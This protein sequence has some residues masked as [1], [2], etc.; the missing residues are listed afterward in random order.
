M[1]KPKIRIW[2][3]LQNGKP[4][5]AITCVEKGIV[6][7]YNEK[8]ELILKRTGLKTQQVKETENTI[9]RY[10]AK[11]VDEHEASFKFL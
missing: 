11:R 1:S 4:M 7:I 3:W 2:I 10:G 6:K 8:D 5:K 9:L